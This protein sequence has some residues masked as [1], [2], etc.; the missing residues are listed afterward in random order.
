MGVDV[1]VGGASDEEFAAVRRLFERWDAVFSRF[2]P[3]SELNSVNRS[4]SPVLVVSELF[5]RAVRAALGAAAATDG[6]VDPTL[7][8][9]LEAAGYDTDF[10]LLRDDDER[11]LGPTAPGRRRTLR[12]SGRLLSRPPGTL[13]DL[14]GVVKGLAVDASVPL[15][16]GDGFVAAGGDVATRGGVVVGLPRGGSVRLAAGGLATS[17]TS[18]R[19][20][21]RGGEAQHHLIDPRT[22]RPAVSRWAEVSVA[23]GSCLAADVAAKAA[24][25]LSE[26]GPDWLDK[27]GLPGRFVGDGGAV[28]NRTWRELLVESLPAAA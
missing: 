26:D 8:R 3:D 19:C 17:G 4:P 6:L 5:A 10:S 14:N 21:R 1:A 12:L 16:R 24:F 7:G 20:W 22:G 11:P 28:V 18:R 9:A 25:L 23:A 27:R 13:L 15:L 2:R